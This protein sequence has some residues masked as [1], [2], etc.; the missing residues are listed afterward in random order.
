MDLLNV[1]KKEI[2]VLS[3]KLHY[4]KKVGTNKIT[5][6]EILIDLI[7]ETDKEIIN[8]EI[9]NSAF[10]ICF[11]ADNAKIY[12]SVEKLNQTI[13]NSIKFLKRIFPNINEKEMFYYY[14]IFALTHETRHVNQYLIANEHIDAPY[15]IVKEVYQTMFK[16]G[17]LNFIQIKNL[18]SEYLYYLHNERLVIERNANIEA[19]EILRNLARFEGNDEIA[20]VFEETRQKNIIYGYDD[21]YNGSVEET[22]KRLYLKSLYDQLTKEEAIPIRDRILYGLPINEET[23]K[24]VLECKY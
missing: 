15:Q 23:R 4:L 12:V 1:K 11:N 13:I 5:I 17:D 2:E 7:A 22:Y 18:I 21:R 3:E 20:N 10:P 9:D 14:T 16:I 19:C 6:L 8:Y 24:K